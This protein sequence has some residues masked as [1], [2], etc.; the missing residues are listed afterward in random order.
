MRTAV[1]VRIK[2][3]YGTFQLKIGFQSDNRRI[4]ILGASGSGKS[5]TLKSIA[6]IER[7]DEG[8]IAIGGKTLYDSENKVF[9]KPQQR[10]VGYLFQNYALFPTMN[11]EKNIGAGLRCG[12]QEKKEKVRRIIERFHLSGLEERLPSELSG[13]QQQ[14]AALARMLVCEPEVILLD[15]PFSALDVYLK[16]KMQRECMELLDDYEGTVILVSHSQ[17]EI[18]R[19]SEEAIVIDEGKL[20]AQKPT[21]E[22]FRSPGSVAAARITGCKN[23]A[24]AEQKPEGLYIPEWDLLFPLKDAGNA[25]AVGIRAHEFHRE[26][27]DGRMAFPVLEPKVTEDLFEYNIAFKTSE[28]AE[29]TIDYKVTKALYDLD[30]EGIPDRLYLDRKDLLLLNR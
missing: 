21:K 20:T 2:K 6:G 18:Y 27:A 28:R 1:E 15:E 23:I 5:L 26:E 4:G 3:D 30:R 14:R 11:V 16:D 29:R 9:V 17:D 24:G 13:G 25:Q 22:L 8:R 12:K 19:F 10:R 7:P